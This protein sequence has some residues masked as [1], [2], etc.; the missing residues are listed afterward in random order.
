MAASAYQDT[1]TVLHWSA[2]TLCYTV[3]QHCRIVHCHGRKVSTHRHC[4]TLCYAAVHCHGQRVLPL[5]LQTYFLSIHFLQIFEHGVLYYPLWSGSLHFSGTSINDD[6]IFIVKRKNQ[7]PWK[8]NLRFPFAFLLDKKQSNRF[9]RVKPKSI[10]RIPAYSGPVWGKAPG[11]VVPL[12]SLDLIYE[13]PVT[14]CGQQG[15][16][17]SDIQPCWTEGGWFLV[18]LC[19]LF[20]VF[21]CQWRWNKVPVSELL[22]KSYN[23]SKFS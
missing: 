19:I 11:R 5:Q 7:W 3:H 20:T 8:Y 14:S 17:I 22:L 13:G 9:M 23:G 6:S 2:L 10:S 21:C 4:A 12:G 1:D 15:D 18:R 16:N